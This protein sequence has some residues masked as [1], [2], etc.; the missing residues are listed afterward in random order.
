[1]GTCGRG[2]GA[3]GLYQAFAQAM[4]RSGDD[5]VLAP[6][7]C[8]GACFQ[9]PLVS[10]RL[11]GNP[12][13]MLR[14]VQA[15]DA[16][17]LLHDIGEGNLSPDLIYCKIEEWDHI[18]GHVRY[19]AGYP[20]V[21]SWND[22]TFF[23][24]QKKIVLRNCGIIN[25]DDIEEYIAVGGYQALYKVLIDANPGNVIEQIKASKLR[26]RG[27][28]GYAT[29]NKWEFL[30]KAKAEPKYI[31]C[32]AD[33]GDPGAYM[34]RNEIES[35]PHS[36]LEGMIIGGYVMGATEG[37]IYVRAEYPLA[38]HRLN[39]AIEQA[40]EYG[41]L[42]ENILGRGFKFDIEL[43]EGAGAFVCGEETALIASL[44]GEAGRPRPRPP[45]P[46]QKGLW[47]KPTNINNVETWYNIAP[48]VMRGP[49]W[50]SETG[51]P[52]SSGTK[53]FSL[54]GKVKN[55]GLVEMPLGTPLK[56]F[57]YDIG[58]GAVEGRQVKAVQTG[59]PSGGCIPQEMFDTAVDYENLAQLGSI[60]GSGGMVVMDEDNCMVD[61]ARYFIEFTHSES[62][63]KCV[64][65]RVGLNKCLRIL[66]RI[67][68]GAGTGRHLDILDELSRYIRDCSL[69]GLGQTAPN[70]VLTTLRHFRNEFEDHIL[71]RRCAAGVCEELA[72]SPCENS[73]PLHMNIPRF[74]QLYKE[75]RLEEAF[76]SIILDNPLPASTGRVCQHPCDNRCRRQTLDQSVNMREVHRFIADTIFGSDKYDPMVKAI[77]ALKLEPT[78]R[79]IAVVGAGP[80]G[81]TA[82]FYL[83]MLGH[84]VTVY[85]SKSE[86]GGMLRF[87]LPEYR[88]PKSILRREIELIEALG[89]TFTFNTRVGV[90]LALNDLDDR[91]DMVF[92][93]IGTWKES[94]VYQSGTELK[95]VYPALNFLEA[96]AAGQDVNLGK[97]VAIIGGGNAAIDSARTSLRKGCDVT[98]FYRRER[99]DMPAIEEETRAARDEG[100]KFVFLAAPHRV[101]GDPKGSVKAIELVK[102]RLGEYDSSGRRK[103]VSTDEIQRFDCDS[104]IFAIGETVDLDFVRASGLV[105][106][107]SGTIDLN[108][109]TL[110]TS[111][112]RFFAGGDL[113][114]GA[115]N[116]SNAMASGKQAARN[117]DLQLM[118]T[119]RWPKL[120][121][122]FE[123]EQTPPEEPSPSRR[124]SG[125]PL[126]A[127]TRVQSQDEVVAGLAQQEAMDEACRCL[128]CDAKTAAVS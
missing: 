92:L 100:A 94:W 73:C 38:V 80:A 126:A 49:A 74:L 86:A 97:R 26:G 64:P 42:G 63:G 15:N 16:A 61:V 36:L 6:V 110:E 59:G 3:E 30:A 95:G 44:E 55:T 108:R 52:K 87:A 40:R 68:E 57:I 116:V 28:A 70:P 20:E 128:R 69:C 50:F 47:G 119:D 118:E 78:G 112:P 107:E 48:I 21:P 75:N 120:Y 60:M 96:V 103:P 23:K 46:A 89:V 31:I 98:V 13:V 4:E 1:M 62:C 88:L 104:V 7:G 32:N 105:L 35:D 14:R 34:N 83:A 72:L 111:R 33:E 109:F 113:V 5:L 9:E 41:L 99:K 25:P 76:L 39:R 91:F 19:G 93:S 101:I 53:V 8:F 58:E 65:C 71:G 27:G 17:R 90:D 18:T 121:P 122:Q 24:G 2:N 84:D 45:F 117:I 125:H 22:V 82:A 114:T 66:N 127:A 67:T 77:V 10:V 56:T 115:S 29:G 79:K 37:I 85:D 11:P 124:H 123:Y 54:V 102:T 106:K 43:V 12:L 51:S 81:L